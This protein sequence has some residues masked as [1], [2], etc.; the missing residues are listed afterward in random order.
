MYSA[1]QR[2][3]PKTRDRNGKRLINRQAPQLQLNGGWHGHEGWARP[4]G[5]ATAWDA[6]RGT[7]LAISR[8]RMSFKE[9]PRF[10]NIAI[11][12]ILFSKWR[13]RGSFACVHRRIGRW[14]R[15]EAGPVL[16]SQRFSVG[17]ASLHSLPHCRGSGRV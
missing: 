6:R 16:P 15:N 17:I 7:A 10:Q 12:S 2:C 14:S 5:C 13:H 9:R 4:G 11:Q 1:L 3:I 8:I